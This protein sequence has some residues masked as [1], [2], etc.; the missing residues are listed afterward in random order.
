[1]RD[2][3]VLWEWGRGKGE[4]RGKGR[5]LMGGRGLLVVCRPLLKGEEI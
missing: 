2:R 1:M 5:P 3:L 4:C